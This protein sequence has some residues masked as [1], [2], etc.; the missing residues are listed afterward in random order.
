M[1][2]FLKHFF[3]T[4]KQQEKI[5]KLISLAPQINMGE[6]SELLEKCTKIWPGIYKLN[7]FK[8]Y[9]KIFNL[10]LGYSRNATKTT[11]RRLFIF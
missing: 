7:G 11:M 2:P 3:V 1:Q 6:S 5:I 10:R 9:E 8:I 4:R